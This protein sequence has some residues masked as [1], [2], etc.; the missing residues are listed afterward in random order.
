MSL[1]SIEQVIEALDS[2]NDI[3]NVAERESTRVDL[4]TQIRD[5]VERN[6]V[7]LRRFLGSRDLCQVDQARQAM[8]L[9]EALAKYRDPPVDVLKWYFRVAREKVCQC[10]DNLTAV[11]VLAS[12]AYLEQGG[13]KALFHL[14]PQYRE[15][16]RSESPPLRRAAIDLL[17]G[18]Q[19]AHAP[20][21]RDALVK[22]LQDTDW[23]VRRDAEV[24]LR[25]DG[26]LPSSYRTTLLDRVRRTFRS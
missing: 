7:E 1:S 22:L 15:L 4:D 11:Q 5:L 8:A 13:G 19:L 17:G 6:Q 2:L 14:L 23:R 18:F 9:V 21:A 24:L 25:E 26:L 3:P 16:C 20:G 10:A 12:F